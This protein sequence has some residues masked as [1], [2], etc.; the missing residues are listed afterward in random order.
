MSLTIWAALGAAVLVVAVLELVM[1]PRRRL[2]ARIAP[3][4]ALARPRLG[5]GP[6]D[7]SVLA[8]TSVDD[9]PAIARVFQPVVDRWFDLAG[10]VV[11]VADDETIRRRLAHAGV[12]DVD[13]DQYRLRQVIDAAIGV[14]V[15]CA[16]GLVVLGSLAG[17]LVFAVLIGFPAATRQR[18]ALERA[19]RER[20]AAMRAEIATVAQLLAVHTRTGAGS[21]E[22]VRAVASAGCGPVSAELRQALGWISGGTSPV[23]AY[24]KLAEATAEPVAARLYRV[25]SGSARSGADVSAGL[26]A[27]AADVRDE[28]RDEVARLAVRRR[29]AMLLPLLLF[30]APVMVLFV[31]AAL[32]SLVFG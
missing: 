25:L 15:G 11:D 22:A 5:A 4:V 31:A 32:P 23:R 12:V 7:L 10:R 3:Y 26:L 18:N 19:T 9:R 17:T 2:G 29:T 30:I 16:F 21:V 6:M 27:V 28:R 1:P 14:A 20:T 8:A 24:D 13:A